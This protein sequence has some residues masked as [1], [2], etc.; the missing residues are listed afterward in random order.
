[1]LYVVRALNGRSK[2]LG[3]F[4]GTNIRDTLADASVFHVR[5]EAERVAVL[6]RMPCSVVEL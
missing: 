5:K 2:W 3:G 1:M 4:E 6:A